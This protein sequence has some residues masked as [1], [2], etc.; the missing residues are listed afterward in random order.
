[1]GA[2]IYSLS[3]LRLISDLPLFGLEVCPNDDKGGCD[4]A[5]RCARIPDEIA[6][7]APRYRDGPYSE[8]SNGKEVLLDIWPVGRFLVREGN[9]ILIE[10]ATPCDHDEARAYLLGLVFGALCHQRGITPLHAS[11]IDVTDGCVAFVGDSGAGKSTMAAILA[12]RGHHVITD[13]VCFVQLSNEGDVRVWPGIRRIRLWEDARAAL[14]FEGPG[15]V[16]EIHRYNKFVIP[17][18]PLR[19]P[20]QSRPLR[21]IYQLRH[22]PKGA[23]Q[24]TRL[25]GSAAAEV[26]MQNVYQSGFAERSGYMSQVFI[27]CAAAAREVPVFQFGRTRDFARMAPGVEMLED[28]LST[29]C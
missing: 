6:S 23:E 25:Q 27:T 11:A 9:E 8:R 17:L 4:V 13:D 29:L 20:K 22:V 3:G 15:I 10:L 5:I 26:L 24:L 18:H 2:L 1:M 16:R 12:Q 7:V 19:N 21:G 28:H 14:G